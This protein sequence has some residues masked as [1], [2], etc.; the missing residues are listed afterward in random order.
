M[1]NQNEGKKGIDTRS[2]EGI[3]GLENVLRLGNTSNFQRK[4][5]MQAE[6]KEVSQQTRMDIILKTMMRMMRSKDNMD[7][8][9][10]WWVSELLVADCQICFLRAFC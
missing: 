4:T 2:G 1:A 3:V 9:N 10:S 5:N 6:K 8:Q 7:A